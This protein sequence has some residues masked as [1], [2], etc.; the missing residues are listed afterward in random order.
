[1]AGV[2]DR[3]KLLKVEALADEVLRTKEDLLNLD[4]HRNGRREAL[5]SLRRGES[6]GATQWLATEGQFLRLPTK[7]TRNWLQSRQGETDEA[8]VAARSR[9]KTQTRALLA[10]NPKVTDLNPGVCDLLLQENKLEQQERAAKIAEASQKQAAEQKALREQKRS[11]NVLDYSR[12]DG[13]A[14]SDCD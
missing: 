11:K 1:M 12:F 13:M 5:G 3:H 7:T 9:L 2:L 4:I 6:R 14:D 10:E 8:I